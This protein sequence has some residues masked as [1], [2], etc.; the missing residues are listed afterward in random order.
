MTKQN[1]VSLTWAPDYGND[2]RNF[3]VDELAGQNTSKL[4]LLDRERIGMPFVTYK[5]SLK[6]IVYEQ[7][8]SKL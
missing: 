5:L 8:A 7:A 6:N 1:R 3:K 2:E 4:N